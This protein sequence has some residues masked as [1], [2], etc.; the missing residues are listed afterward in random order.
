MQVLHRNLLSSAALFYQAVLLGSIGGQSGCISLCPHPS[1][2]GCRKNLN[3]EGVNI[4]LLIHSILF[5][6]N[7]LPGEVSTV[8]PVVHVPHEYDPALLRQRPEVA[9]VLV[10]VCTHSA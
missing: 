1:H 8:P 5:S 2:C 3:Q 7:F 10:Q 9:E 4:F 6:E